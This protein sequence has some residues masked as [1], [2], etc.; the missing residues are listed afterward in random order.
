MVCTG[1]ALLC[2]DINLSVSEDG[3]TQFYNVCRRGYT[4]LKTCVL[5]GGI[6]NHAI[7]A[8]EST[9]SA[10]LAEASCLL[11]K[12]QNPKIIGLDNATLDAQKVGIKLA[13][14]IGATINDLSS[15]G[16]VEAII[17]GQIPTCSLEEVK[18][19]ADTVIYWGANPH[20]FH[21]RHLSRFYYSYPEDMQAG[22]EL[23]RTLACVDVRLSEL[24]EIS[25]QVFRLNPGTDG[26]FLE[27]VLGLLQR[28]AAVNSSAR[29]FVKLVCG[30][31]YCVIYAGLGLV[32]VLGSR[33]EL[34]IKVIQA[35]GQY[36]SIQVIPMVSYPNT[37]GLYE[38]LAAE[39]SLAAL[40]QEKS[41]NCDCC[42]VI[43]ANQL[44]PQAEGVVDK[45]KQIP[46]I[47]VDPFPALTPRPA[48][49]SVQI[50]LPG[51]ETSGEMVRL[52]GMKISLKPK[53]TQTTLTDKL[54]LEML[55][56]AI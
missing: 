14:R 45:L 38:L 29:D 21:P 17:E 27:S 51:L 44:M 47:S 2:D 56:E 11:S 6:V 48:A 9:L 33:L 22:G 52:D 43:G 54:I 39:K 25:N 3:D 50:G 19:R 8:Q 10:C 24:T 34:F 35:L 41:E 4:M 42:L 53:L 5:E 46:V 7:Q 26:E 37:R 1:C 28:G 12:A 13:R 15:I 40:K 55:M 36:T 31:R 32:R 20:K 30:S 23:Q 18:R 16:I 49:V